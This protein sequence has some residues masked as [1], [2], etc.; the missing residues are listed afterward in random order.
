MALPAS[1]MASG[2][3]VGAGGDHL[4]GGGIG[5]DGQGG[6]GVGIGGVS[7]KFTQLNIVDDDRF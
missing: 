7:P 6:S 2:L 3:G 5:S 1:M 4:I